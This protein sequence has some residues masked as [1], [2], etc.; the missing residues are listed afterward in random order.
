MIVEKKMPCLDVII[1]Y[2][3]EGEGIPV[4]FL[5][6]GGGF[7]HIWDRQI[8]FF[9]NSYRVIALDLPGFGES[10]ESLRPYTIDYYSGIL[11]CF[12]KNL[13]LG[14]IIL[15]GNCIG[16]TL[17]IRYKLTWPAHVI[18]L[19]L[20]NICPGERLIPSQALSVVLFRIN[21]RWI[22]VCLQSLFRFLLTKSPAR[23]RFPDILFGDDPDPQSSLYQRYL[24]KFKDPK[25]T[26]SRVN[27]LFAINTYSLNRL[28]TEN[29]PESDTTAISDALLL[30][31]ENNK[32][33]SLEKEG[34]YHRN[35]CGIPH[36][37]V[38]PGG[39]HL[40]MAEFPQLV[41]NI[42]HAYLKA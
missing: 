16:A 31:G 36:M 5:H 17:A 22:T 30:W 29:R 38:I 8:A 42:I 9:K 40:L 27:L 15:V 41:N 2:I 6:N 25:Q 26:R 13:N 39:G 34:Y 20:M 37:H 7:Y 12:F 35:L 4:V 24:I 3:D 10:T 32:V 28:I 14:R 33:A 1:N 21:S 23:R 18:K 11:E 19:V